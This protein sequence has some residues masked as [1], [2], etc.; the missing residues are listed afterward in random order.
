MVVWYRFQPYMPT[1]V[2]RG[3]CGV[4]IRVPLLCAPAGTKQSLSVGA[5]CTLWCHEEWC[6]H[7][8]LMSHEK[9]ELSAHTLWF[10]S[11]VWVAATHGV[12]E[13]VLLSCVLH[14]RCRRL[15][16]GMGPCLPAMS[17]IVYQYK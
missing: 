14:H 2:E 4:I 16:H 17:S 7:K 8:L 11:W 1:Q 6:L 12:V 15:V 3:T 9:I 10:W 5:G 13:W